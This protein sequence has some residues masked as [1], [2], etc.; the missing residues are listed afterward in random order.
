M[1]IAEG[2]F[3]A[4]SASERFGLPAW[5]LLSTRNMRAW[6]APQGV[7]SVLIAGDNGVDGR[8]SAGVLATRLEVQGLR[9][10]TMFP[11]SPHGDW[12]DLASALAKN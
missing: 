11:D 1:L 8:R 7:T 10:R 9:T 6:I 5:A 4:L 3:T 2:F 12:N